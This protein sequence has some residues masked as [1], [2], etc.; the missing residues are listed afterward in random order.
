[1][2]IVI[3]K[4]IESLFFFEAVYLRELIFDWRVKKLKVSFVTRLGSDSLVGQNIAFVQL[5]DHPIYADHAGVIFRLTSHVVFHVEGNLEFMI[6]KALLSRL[7]PA[8]Y[9]RVGNQ[10]ISPF[11]QALKLN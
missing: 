1:M 7:V 3:I 6:V 5:K 10:R 11:D 9:L 4:T 2:Y 8:G